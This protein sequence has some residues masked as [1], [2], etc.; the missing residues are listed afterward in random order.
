MTVKIG[1][2]KTCCG[3][4]ALPALLACFSWLSGLRAGD[5]RACAMNTY[6][7]SLPSS[8]VSTLSYPLVLFSD[9][10]F[11]LYDR[12]VCRYTTAHGLYV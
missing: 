6:L 4:L 5:W 8:T 9:M 3:L 12:M 2:D 10:L 11:V 1:G 7:S